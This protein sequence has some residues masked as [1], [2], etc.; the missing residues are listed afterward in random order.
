MFEDER[1]LLRRP[2]VWLTLLSSVEAIY[3]VDRHGW[4]QIPLGCRYLP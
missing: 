2:C 3:D 4:L 1:L